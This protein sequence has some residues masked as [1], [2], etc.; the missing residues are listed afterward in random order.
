MHEMNSPNYTSAFGALDFVLR[1]SNED[2][3]DVSETTGSFWNRLLDRLRDLF[4]K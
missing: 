1:A 3:T 4:I 2:D